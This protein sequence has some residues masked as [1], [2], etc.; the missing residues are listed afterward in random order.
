[1]G[2][3]VATSA[4]RRVLVAGAGLAGTAAA[5]ALAAGGVLTELLLSSAELDD[6][7]WAAFTARRF[8]RA[9]A[10]VE[11]S[12]RLT[13]WQL[14]HEQGDVMALMASITALITEPA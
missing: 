2:D 6:A 13:Q 7:L 14:D 4:V 5:I 10:V 12:C 9:R 11:A 3:P 1:M 8:E